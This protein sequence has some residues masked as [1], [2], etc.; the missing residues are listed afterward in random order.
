MGDQKL[1]SVATSSK[2]PHLGTH[3]LYYA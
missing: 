3:S 2:H 1:P